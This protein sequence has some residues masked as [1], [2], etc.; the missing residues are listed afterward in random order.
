MGYLLLHWQPV[1][2]RAQSEEYEVPPIPMHMPPLLP[3][4]LTVTL[5]TS[6]SWSTITGVCVAT[7]PNGYATI[8]T[9][10][11]YYYTEN[12]YILEHNHRSMLY[13]RSLCIYHHYYMGYLFL[14]WK[15][16]YRRAQSQGYV[17]PPIAMHIP[18][19][20]HWLL[21]VT[22]EPVYARAQSQEYVVPPIPMHIPPLL[23]GLLTVTLGTS[24]S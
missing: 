22:W 16:V 3:G 1:Y 5:G 7:D 23:H 10:A 19:L 24:I 14:H 4:L 17:V 6:I 15:P 21:T 8:I 9:W 2:R 11:T 13:L 18:P 12:Q 20:L